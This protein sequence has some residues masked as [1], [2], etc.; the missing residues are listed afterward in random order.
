MHWCKSASMTRV[1]YSKFWTRSECRVQAG[2]DGVSTVCAWAWHWCC[3]VAGAPIVRGGRYNMTDN[4]IL[5]WL[6][7]TT[8]CVNRF[9][10]VAVSIG[11][12]FFWSQS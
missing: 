4:T 6:S 7:F 11:H 10:S 9:G 1:H 3:V 8:W 2:R 12:M 5:I